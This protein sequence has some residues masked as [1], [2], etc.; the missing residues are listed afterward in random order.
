MAEVFHS[1]LNHCP[2][3]HMMCADGYLQLFL[4]KMNLIANEFHKSDIPPLNVIH[5]NE[6]LEVVK[7]LTKWSVASF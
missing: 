3:F 4:N 5:F 7:W 6:S 2:N 1:I